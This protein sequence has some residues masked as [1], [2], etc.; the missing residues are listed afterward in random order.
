M[1]LY[2]VIVYFF[3]VRFI[4]IFK[5][6][7]D[8]VYIAVETLRVCFVNDS[9]R[10]LWSLSARAHGWPRHNDGALRGLG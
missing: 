7:C 4:K 10:F 6:T 3:R 1:Y 5:I 9:L 2:V 8:L